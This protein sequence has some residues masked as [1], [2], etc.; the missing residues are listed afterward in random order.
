MADSLT[1]T[2]VASQSDPVIGAVAIT[3]ADQEFTV[4]VRG[5]YVATAGNL[6]C[7][8]ANASTATFIGLLAGVIYPFSITHIRDAGTT[9]T[10]HVLL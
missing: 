1:T 5:V 3:G 2:Q 8:L 4:H 9:C 10:G 6:E 7:T